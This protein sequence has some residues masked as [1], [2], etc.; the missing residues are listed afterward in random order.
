MEIEKMMLT[1]AEYAEKVGKSVYTIKKGVLSGRFKTAVKVDGIW[2]ISEEEDLSD[3]RVKSGKFAGW[4]EKY[5]RKSQE[6]S[7]DGD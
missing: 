2:M 4:R 3:R 7:Q 5:G 1:V 6:K